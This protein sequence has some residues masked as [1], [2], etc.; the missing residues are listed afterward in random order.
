[1]IRLLT[2]AIISTF[3]LIPIAGYSSNIIKSEALLVA[4]SV[5]TGYVIV[6]I[7]LLRLWP[8]AKSD[9]D[10]ESIEIALAKGNVST[11]EYD[12]VEVVQ[13]EEKED[14]GLHFLMAIAPGKTLSF[15]G[16]YLYPYQDNKYFPS[17]RIRIIFNSEK[18]YCYGIECIGNKL[19]KIRT[20]AP[21]T[22]EAYA[23]DVVPFDFQF[24]SKPL[25]DVVAEI[26]R[27]A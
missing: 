21:P 25:S 23:A 4:V 20:I 16:Q 22:S 15:C 27:Y 7:L 2:I 1:M 19:N 9:A 26:E 10:Y 3:L 17:D 18:G 8:E 24:I 11:S 12:V 13:M 14:E 5:I 6:P